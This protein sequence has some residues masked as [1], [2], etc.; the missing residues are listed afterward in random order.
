MAKKNKYIENDKRKTY[1][2]EKIFE[3]FLWSTR[4]LVIL[5]VISSLF[6]SLVLFIMASKDVYEVV[7]DIIMSFTGNGDVEN[8]HTIIVSKIVGAIDI[9]LIA[10]VLLIFSFGLYELFI[11]KINPAEN[12]EASNILN[13][14]SLDVLK[15]KIAQVIIMA[16]IVKYFQIVLDLT[17]N[18]NSPIDMAYFA[19][20]IL[21][22]SLGLYFMHK[23]KTHGNK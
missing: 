5:A 4:Y 6:A 18:F 16:L 10:V 1:L 21:A 9:Y 3:K 7:V 11:S 13:I 19:G 15:E 20:A 14:D 2:I 17:K 8:F 22:L 23:G 12:S